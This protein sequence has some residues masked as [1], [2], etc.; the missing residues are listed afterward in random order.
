VCSAGEIG[1]A[2]YLIVSGTL[3]AWKSSG[4]TGFQR[5]VYDFK[6]NERY[7][8]SHTCVYMCLWAVLSTARLTCWCRSWYSFGDTALMHNYVRSASVKA[9]TDCVLWELKGQT[10]RS[11]LMSSYVNVWI[12]LCVVHTHTCVCVCVCVCVIWCSSRAW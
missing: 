9:R 3:E 12:C 8:K 7:V 2:F 1:D 10:Y 4:S 11:I 5:K 6:R